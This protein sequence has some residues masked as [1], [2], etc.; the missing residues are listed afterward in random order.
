MRRYDLT[1]NMYDMRY[2]EEQEAEYSAALKHLTMKNDLV[3]DIGCGTGLF[4]SHVSAGAR[5]VCG[6][7]FSR[8][9]LVQAKRRA[10]HL[11]NVQ[12]VLADA[13]HLPLRKGVVTVVF[14]FTVVQNVPN[15]LVTLGEIRNIV[16]DDADVVLTGLKRIFTLN[17][18]KKLLSDAGLKI[19]F[20]E[21]E[22]LQCYVAVCEFVH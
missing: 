21:S 15:P 7:D 22:G 11:H 16:C 19:R 14:A 5:M 13:D 6:I 4:F 17:D 1:A 10:D 3:L 8:K 9:T 2:G 20:L 18:F 12:V